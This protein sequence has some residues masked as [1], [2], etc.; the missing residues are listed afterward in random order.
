LNIVRLAGALT[1]VGLILM[2]VLLR[3]RE[4]RETR[5]PGPVGVS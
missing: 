2:V 3:R 5:T 1:V 4:T